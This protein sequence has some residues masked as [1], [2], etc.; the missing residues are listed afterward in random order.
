MAA[1]WHS[2][3][4]LPRNAK[5]HFQAVK[6]TLAAFSRK[7]PERRFLHVYRAAAAC[8]KMCDSDRN[9]KTARRQI[10]SLYGGGASET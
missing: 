2:A 4:S 3:N 10:D 8:E 7:G 5:V 1:I 9:D 6:R